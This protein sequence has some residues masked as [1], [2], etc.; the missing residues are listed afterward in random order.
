MADYAELHCLSNFTFLRGA[1]HPEELVQHAHALDYRSLALTDECSVAGAVKAH[2]AARKCGL[3]L[4]IGS[5][6]C[7]ADGPRVVLLA[8]NRMGYRNLVRLITK[9]RR[10]ASKGDYQLASNDISSP[11]IADCLGL[12]S[13]DPS[14]ATKSAI[15]RRYQSLE[16]NAIWLNQLLPHQTW[17]TVEQPANGFDHEHL[18]FL[19]SV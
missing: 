17:I 3:P 18:Q 11:E 6:F 9:A 13:C 7:L 10:A 4:I 5:E 12:L 19:H 2:V 8:K 1:S 14:P 16:Q 15:T